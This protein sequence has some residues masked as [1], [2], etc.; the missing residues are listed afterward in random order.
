MLQKEKDGPENCRRSDMPVPKDSQ[1][2]APNEAQGNAQIA[3]E[4][5]AQHLAKMFAALAHP[6][7]SRI[8]IELGS[9][10]H[11]VNN[12]ADTLKISH[13]SVS[14]HLAILRSQGLIK[15]QKAGR[16]VFY[17]L[18]APEL[19]AWL[20]AGGHFGENNGGS[21]T[22]SPGQNGNDA[23]NVT[24]QAVHESMLNAMPQSR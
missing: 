1:N 11:C 7:R 16:F 2:A 18:I 12:L 4:Q 14:Q 15:E 3:S 5:L 6:A 21:Q 9:G 8:I 23:E 13:S 17:R 22:A 24:P 20:A 19:A 10:E